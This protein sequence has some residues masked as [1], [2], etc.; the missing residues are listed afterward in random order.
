MSYTSLTTAIKPNDGDRQPR[1]AYDEPVD[2]RV[3]DAL[4]QCNLS[5]TDK[6][7]DDSSGERDGH[8]GQWER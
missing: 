4:Q 3:A 7:G 1:A 5:G 8:N 2:G 6:D